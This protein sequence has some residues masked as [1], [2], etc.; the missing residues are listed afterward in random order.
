LVSVPSGRAVLAAGVKCAELK[1]RILFSP[2][3]FVSDLDE[4]KLDEYLALIDKK[5]EAAGRRDWKCL[6][7]E[8]RITLRAYFF[9]LDVSNGEFEKYFLERGDSWR[10]TLHAIRTVGASHL[11]AL[12]EEALAAFPGGIPS[13]D[14]ETRYNQLVAAGAL[15][16]EGLFW[17]LTGE[18]FKLQE[19]SPQHCLYQRLTAFAI[20]QLDKQASERPNPEH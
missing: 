6:N 11:A 16:G 8:E 2:E 5:L 19:A 3:N 20:K 1:K 15:G 12:F 9:A 17:R 7:D 13:S 18:Y 4:N 10:E 14:P